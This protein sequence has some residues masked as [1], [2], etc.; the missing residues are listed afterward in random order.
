MPESFLDRFNPH[1]AREACAGVG[2][3]PDMGGDMLVYAGKPGDFGE[4]DI[5]FLV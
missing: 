3:S 4:V 2:M 1:T 5:V